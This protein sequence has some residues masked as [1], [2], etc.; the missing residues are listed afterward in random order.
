MSDTM[1]DEPASPTGH[2]VLK[3][4]AQMTITGLVLNGVLFLAAGR[5]DWLS[6][7]L[8]VALWMASKI[9]YVLIIGQRDPALIAERAR[10]PADQKPWDRVVLTLYLV[11]CFATIVAAGLDARCRRQPSAGSVWIIAVGVVIYVASLALATWATASNPFHSRV[12]RI[13]DD[14]GHTVATAGPYHYLRHPTY[15]ATIVG[16]LGT[17]PILESWWALIPAA[18]AGA[19]MIL[20]T[21]LEDRMLHEELPGYADYARQVRY[22]L[23]PGIW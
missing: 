21:A 12:S 17:P 4:L 20:R 6:G 7:W 10:Q 22:R 9:A 3:H 2:P 5:V 11:F 1:S 13:Q 16:W 18:L 23:L 19:M 14:R 15:L 8:Y